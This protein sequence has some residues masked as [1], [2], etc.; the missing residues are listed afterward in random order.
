MIVDDHPEVRKTF[1]WLLDMQPGYAVI[2]EAANGHEAIA[3]VKAKKP[4]LILMDVEMPRLN[5]AQATLRIKK[6]H[7]E[8][9]IIGISIHNEGAYARQMLATGADGYITKD[10]AFDELMSA[11][12]HVRNGGTYLPAGIKGGESYRD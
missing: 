10:C 5:G 12:R 2:A 4:D 8:I 6:L 9:R 7:P 11:I 3:A 1:R